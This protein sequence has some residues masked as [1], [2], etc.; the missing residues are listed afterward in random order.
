MTCV[1]RCSIFVL[2]LAGCSSDPV[3]PPGPPPRGA[4]G[5][6]KA[7]AALGSYPAPDAWEANAGPGAGHVS[8]DAAQLMTNC[9]FLDGGEEDRTDHHNLVTMYDGYLLMPWAP[10]WAEGGLTLWDVSDPCSPQTVGYGTSSFMRETHSI[11]FSSIGGRWAAV[12]YL[13][14][15]LEGGTEFWDVSDPTSPTPVSNVAVDGFLYPDAYARVSLSLFWQVPYLFVAAADNGVFVIDATDPMD[16][17]V[18]K[19]VSF[20]PV[21]RAGQVQAIGNVLVVT[22]A[23]GPRTVLLDIST[24]EDPQPIGGGDF[25]IRDGNGDTRESYFSNVGGGYVYYARKDDGGGVIVYDIHDPSNPQFAGDISGQGN[26]GYVFVKDDIAFVGEGNFAAAYDVADPA[27]ISL[28]TD[29]FLL[30]GDLDTIT[31]I[32]NYVVLSVD[33]EANPDEGSAIAPFDAAPDTVAPP[34]DVGLP[35]RW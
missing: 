34:R 30:P 13:G 29:A 21:L 9:A 7:D 6:C 26:G 4:A 35:Q 14:G 27:N 11:G 2:L 3:E 32:A 5:L 22:E 23:E 25:S 10:E 1:T 12:N 18:V 20:E 33:D 8:F 17:F 15:I 24:P 19:Q 28:I 31:P 16:P